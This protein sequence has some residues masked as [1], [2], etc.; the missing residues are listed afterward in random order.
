MATSITLSALYS[1]AD[2]F[3]NSTAVVQVADNNIFGGPKTV[4]HINIVSG[5]SGVA[6]V[7]LYDALTATVA[8]DPAM[9]IK[10]AAGQTENVAIPEGLAFGTGVCMRCVTTGGTGGVTDPGGGNVAVIVVGS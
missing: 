2:T 7:K 8:D 1:F 3:Y 9:I 6:Y 5:S 4:Y 10:V